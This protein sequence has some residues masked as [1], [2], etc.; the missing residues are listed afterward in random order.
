MRMDAAALAMAAPPPRPA[1]APRARGRG[2]RASAPAGAGRR[3]GHAWRCASR[4][5][6]S[7]A[8]TCAWSS[9]RAPCGRRSAPLPGR[10]FDLADGRL[11]RPARRSGGQDGAPGFR[12]VVPRRRAAR[13]LCLTPPSAPRRCAGRARAPRRWWPRGGARRREDPRA[14]AGGGRSGARGPRAG[15]RA[16]PAGAGRRGAG[17]DVDGGR[18]GARLGLRAGSGGDYHEWVIEELGSSARYRHLSIAVPAPRR[19]S[20]RHEVRR[21]RTGSASRRRS[22]SRCGRSTSGPVT[23]RPAT[24]SS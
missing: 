9:P 6:R 1:G 10:S 22:L 18:G 19:S 8:S 5:R 12:R 15:R 17:G 21:P 14:R 16:G 7:A 2:R 23:C 24:V 13:S 3:G 11:G 20:S 4:R